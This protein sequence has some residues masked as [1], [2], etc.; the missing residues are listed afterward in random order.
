MTWELF[1]TEEGNQTA[2]KQADR[3]Q[4]IPGGFPGQVP[5]IIQMEAG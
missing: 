2:E 1:S 3:S 5:V 4:A